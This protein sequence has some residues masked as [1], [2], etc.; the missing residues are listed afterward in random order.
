M[1]RRNGLLVALVVAAVFALTGCSSTS[2]STT[3]PPSSVPHANGPTTSAPATRATP[4]SA[5]VPVHLDGGPV[6]IYAA[7]RP[8]ALSD[9]VKHDRALIYVP[10]SLSDTVDVIDPTTRAS[11]ST[12]RSAGYPN[13]SFP[14]GT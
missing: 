12:S 4:S 5:P 11:S 10:N 9:V 14:L 3:Q 8:N 6:D 7:D 13:T 2:H 1:P